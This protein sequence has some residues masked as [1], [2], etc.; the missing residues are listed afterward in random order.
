MRATAQ[1]ERFEKNVQDSR[2]FPCEFNFNRAPSPGGRDEYV[3]SH[4]ESRWNGW[5][6]ALTQQSDA[7]AVSPK[8]QPARDAQNQRER[9]NEWASNNG[10]QSDDNAFAAYQFGVSEGDTRDAARVSQLKAVMPLFQESRDALTALSVA[11]CKR[12][13]IRLDLADR[14]DFA[15]NADN[16]SALGK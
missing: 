1:G 11:Q 12:H 10:Y 2:F 14:M 16:F 6:A 3:N 15:G 13:G 5:Q 9:F 4:L 7:L 8:A